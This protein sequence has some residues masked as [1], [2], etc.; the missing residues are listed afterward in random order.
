MCSD[1]DF[2][3]GNRCAQRSCSPEF[4]TV[5]SCVPRVKNTCNML[6]IKG[7]SG[8]SRCGVESEILREAM[9]DIGVAKNVQKTV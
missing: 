1:F 2:S 8:R 3:S 9:P 4:L 6:N 7:N 5:D